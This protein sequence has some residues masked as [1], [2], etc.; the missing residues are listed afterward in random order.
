MSPDVYRAARAWT[1]KA[2]EDRQTLAIL[3]AHPDAPPASVCFHAQQAAEKAIKAV[4]TGAGRPFPKSH[5]LVLLATLLPDDAPVAPSVAEQAEL[6]YFAVLA[7][8]PGH[9]TDVDAAA[10]RRL[11]GVAE[12]VL[13]AAVRWLDGRTPP[14]L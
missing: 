11:A 6:T 3:T 7:R 9:A 8:Y 14:A 4:L 13:D 12:A 5:D 1:A 10:A 2:E